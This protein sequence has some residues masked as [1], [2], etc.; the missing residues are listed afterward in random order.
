MK[1]S[2]HEKYSNNIIKVMRV[3]DLCQ[4]YVSDNLMLIFII[5]GVVMVLAII[6]T[7]S[8]LICLRRK[9]SEESYYMTHIIS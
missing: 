6:S 4:C 5:V 2:L 7:T 8:V 1:K 9:V 3:S